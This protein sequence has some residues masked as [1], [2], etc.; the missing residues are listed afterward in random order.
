MTQY[1]DFSFSLQ[2][3]VFSPTQI[4]FTQILSTQAQIIAR[5]HLIDTSHTQSPDEHATQSCEKI[6][7]Y[8]FYANPDFTQDQKPTLH[9]IIHTNQT[10]ALL[11]FA[12]S[13]ATTIP[14]SLGFS[15]IDLQVCDSLQSLQPITI[16]EYEAQT[17]FYTAT[18]TQD[19]LSDEHFGDFKLF[20][21]AKPLMHTQD[22]SSYL[23]TILHNL[24]SNQSVVLDTA[25]GFKECSLT[26]FQNTTQSLCVMC[27]ISSLKTFFRIHTAQVDILASFE[28]P[29]VSLAPKEVFAD[30]FPLDSHGL[31]LT[32]LPYDAIL[33]LMSALLLREEITHFFLRDTDMTPARVFSHTPRDSHILCVSESGLFV[34]TAQTQCDFKTLLHTNLAHHIRQS[35]DDSKPTSSVVFYISSKHPSAILL[36]TGESFKQLL[37]TTFEANPQC[38]I[39]S[40]RTN[41]KSGAEL[42]E[43]FTKKLNTPLF[44]NFTTT[45]I[46]TD[47]LTHIFGIAALLLGMH[48]NTN[49][50]E[51]TLLQTLPHAY[52]SLLACANQFLRSKGPRID[53]ILLRDTDNTLTLD[54]PRIFRSSMSF[55]CADM[56]NVILAYGFID[57]FCEF[58]ATL[59]RDVQTNYAF[60]ENL[61][62]LLC[63]D[64]FG[65]SIF[66]ERI[67]GFLPKNI[68]LTLPQDGFLDYC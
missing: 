2:P 50:N 26:P 60:G 25:R 35:H 34:D 24:K 36:R 51:E 6:Y 15:F 54:Y 32:A 27:D 49:L 4:F 53:Y 64:V 66:L 52:D 3:P 63:G 39:E 28:K 19:F 44:V 9:F 8:R 1:Y 62:V 20:S 37:D 13:L 16:P 40:I 18:Q 43:N 56:E 59:V 67:L 57:S 11:D 14:L 42:V 30:K 7:T 65:Q 48:P 47:N 38:L 12:E 68:T 10:Q 46:R 5:Q 61:E 41:Y 21:F 58:L 29:F 17:H 22:I 33:Q 45:S 55:K 23:T 31:M